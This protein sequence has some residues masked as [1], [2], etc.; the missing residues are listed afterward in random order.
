MWQAPFVIIFIV[1][2][3]CLLLLLPSL[4]LCYCLIRN[5]EAAAVGREAEIVTEQ[6]EELQKPGSR[7]LEPGAVPEGLCLSVSLLVSHVLLVPAPLTRRP[8]SIAFIGP[9]FTSPQH[10]RS[11]QAPPTQSPDVIPGGD[12]G[13]ACLPRPTL[14]SIAVAKEDSV[15]RL[16]HMP[17]SVGEGG[18]MQPPQCGLEPGDRMIS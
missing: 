9:S 7:A 10:L 3:P 11:K 4:I 6:E 13:P 12:S 16:G 5:S 17:F 8:N 1:I 15:P 14:G 18:L 2:L